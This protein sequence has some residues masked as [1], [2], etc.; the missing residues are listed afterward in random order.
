MCALA[1]G[2]A[3]RRAHALHRAPPFRRSTDAAVLTPLGPRDAAWRDAVLA[4]PRRAADAFA[5]VG[6][7]PGR[8]RA[9]ARAA[10]AVERGARGASR[11]TTPSATL[12]KARR[13]GSARGAQATR[14]WPRRSRAGRR[15]RQSRTGR[16]RD[17]VHGRRHRLSPPRPRRRCCRAAGPCGSR[18]AFVGA[19]EDDGARYWATDGDRA[20]E[21]Q[22]LTATRP[23]TPSSCSR[24]RPR[25]TR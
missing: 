12:L 19:W 13:R 9:L 24:W 23:P 2:R 8:A 20:I 4:D 17:G 22:S 21:F 6:R 7:G 15:R 11:S 1:R 5:V 16:R 25:C 3:A 10:R 14:T 18:G